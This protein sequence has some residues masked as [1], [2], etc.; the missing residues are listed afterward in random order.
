[1]LYVNVHVTVEDNRREISAIRYISVPILTQNLFLMTWPPL[2]MPG[3]LF[4]M[5]RRE[6]LHVEELHHMLQW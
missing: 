5:L 2:C 1:M 3:P 6:D 4:L